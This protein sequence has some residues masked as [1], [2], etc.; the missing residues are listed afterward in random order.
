MQSVVLVTV[1]VTNFLVWVQNE[2]WHSK[3]RDVKI[4]L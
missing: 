4:I 3:T 2:E 1:K